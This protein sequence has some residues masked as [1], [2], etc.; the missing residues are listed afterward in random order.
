VELPPVKKP[1]IAHLKGFQGVVG[2]A[3][4]SSAG[5]RAEEKA[6]RLCGMAKKAER[7]YG[8]LVCFFL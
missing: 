1:A 6:N 4:R 7:F 8:A 5:Q 3:V 2:T